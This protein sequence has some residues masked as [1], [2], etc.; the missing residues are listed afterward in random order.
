[1]SDVILGENRWSL[2]EARRHDD[3][4]FGLVKQ[5]ERPGVSADVFAQKG[6]KLISDE[7]KTYDQNDHVT[8]VRVWF[9]DDG[10]LVYKLDDRGVLIDQASALVRL[11]RDFGI[12]VPDDLLLV[13]DGDVTLLQMEKLDFWSGYR[14]NKIVKG[15]HEPPQGLDATHLASLYE[16][17][18]KVAMS[19]R[20]HIMARPFAVT[21]F[22]HGN[23]GIKTEAFLQWTKGAKLDAKDVVIF[24]PVT[25]SYKKSK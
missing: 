10:K 11:Q 4:T 20:A 17:G 2:I 19:C 14:I 8:N 24:D 12:K 21:G 22:H 6:W 15:D 7:Q 3:L 18:R 1:M 16:Q 5:L 13:T 9:S 23:W 25:M